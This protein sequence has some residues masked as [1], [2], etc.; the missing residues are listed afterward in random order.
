MEKS[1]KKV[2]IEKLDSDFIV[3]KSKCYNETKYPY[4]PYKA[5]VWDKVKFENK[6]SILGAWETGC[7][8]EREIN[9]YNSFKLGKIN[10]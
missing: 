6:Y 4:K 1:F 5:L 9:G 7:I 3:K 10:Y 8:K 2:K